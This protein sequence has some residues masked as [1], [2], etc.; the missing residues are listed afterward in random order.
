MIIPGKMETPLLLI[1][2]GKRAK[3]VVTHE[4]R[5]PFLPMCRALQHAMLFYFRQYVSLRTMQNAVIQEHMDRAFIS[6]H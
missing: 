2:D 3:P 4:R 1:V 6:P 5:E